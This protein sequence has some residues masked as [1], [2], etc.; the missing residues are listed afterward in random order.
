M[1]RREFIILPG[2]AVA[3]WPRTGR[4]QHA[5]RWKRIGV[6]MGLVQNDPSSRPYIGAFENRL[7]SLGWTSGQNLQ[8]DYRWTG[9]DAERFRADAT[10]LAN[11]SLDAILA[12][13][14]GALQSLQRA[15]T[16]VPIVFVQVTNPDTGGF[17]ASLERP[18]GNITGISNPDVSVVGIR[19]KMLKEIA[20]KVARALAIFEPDYPTV[21]SSLRAFEAAAAQLGVLAVSVGA[22]DRRAS[23]KPSA[24]LRASR[25]ADC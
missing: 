7:Q 21:P 2:L 15:T 9:G 17:V 23:K 6:L 8:I 25:M 10:E 5:D 24:N 3:A 19:L 12:T 13:S 20:P 14:T 4:A 16:T 18:G 1:R 11:F 22:P